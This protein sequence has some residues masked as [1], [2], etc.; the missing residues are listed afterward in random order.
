M[1]PAA[2]EQRVVR[3]EAGRRVE[4]EAR[5]VPQVPQPG[6]L[7]VPQPKNVTGTVVHW[8]G[9]GEQIRKE[10]R[11]KNTEIYRRAA[12]PENSNLGRMQI[13]SCPALASCQLESSNPGIMKKLHAGSRLDASTVLF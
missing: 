9:V 3:G 2:A 8:K 1:S 4:H 10:E 6:V 11:G 5:E 13:H 12:E 7:E